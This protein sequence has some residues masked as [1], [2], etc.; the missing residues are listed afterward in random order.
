MQQLVKHLA[1]RQIGQAVMGREIFD[2]L[3]GP[4]FLVG[5]IEVYQC[6]RNVVGKSLQQID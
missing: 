2:P 3:I 6:K 1:I 4:R 5:T